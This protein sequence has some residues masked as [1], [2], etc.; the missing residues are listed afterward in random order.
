MLIQFP[1]E[2]CDHILQTDSQYCGQKTMCPNCQTFMIVPS[3]GLGPQTNEPPTPPSPPASVLPSSMNQLTSSPG[4][5]QLPERS[6]SSRLPPIELELPGSGPSSGDKKRQPAESQPVRR[7]S[8]ERHARLP[9]A[10]DY[11]FSVQRMM[12]LLMLFLALFGITA[13]ELAGFLLYS[14]ATLEGSQL[15]QDVVEMWVKIWSH[16]YIYVTFAWSK[17]T[18]SLVTVGMLLL[19]QIPSVF[20]QVWF[21]QGLVVMLCCLLVFQLMTVGWLAVCPLTKGISKTDL[22]GIA[23]Q[24]ALEDKTYLPFVPDTFTLY[25]VIG[26][27]VTACLIIFALALEFRRLRGLAGEGYNG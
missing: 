8:S 21:R 18:S 3:A 20:R 25:L 26:A 7:Q 11:S 13:Y 19:G 22:A 27:G 2:G 6:I 9:A 14:R 24:A 16:N 4:V 12:V 17:V 1:C 5:P 15:E 10:F 23:T